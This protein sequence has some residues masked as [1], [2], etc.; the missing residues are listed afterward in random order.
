VAQ[1]QGRIRQRAAAD[2]DED[3]E[4]FDHLLPVFRLAEGG[5]VSI[6]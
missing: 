6:I 4:Q 3:Q 1:N 5:R 2:A